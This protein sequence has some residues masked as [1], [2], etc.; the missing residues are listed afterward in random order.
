ML[1]APVGLSTVSFRVQKHTQYQ[2]TNAQTMTNIYMTN[3]NI[4]HERVSN[5]RL[6][7]QQTVLWPLR[8]R[9]VEILLDTKSTDVSLFDCLSLCNNIPSKIGSNIKTIISQNRMNCTIVIRL[10]LW[11]RIALL[12]I[13]SDK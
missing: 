13:C 12:L 5:P 8:Q 7:A 9:I 10:F 4:E 11:S 1:I 2:S 6:Q 3:T